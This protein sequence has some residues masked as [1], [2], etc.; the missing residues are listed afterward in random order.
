VE[1]FISQA[2]W[3]KPKDEI[4]SLKS[5]RLQIAK[6]ETT[7]HLQDFK[8]ELVKQRRSMA[9]NAAENDQLKNTV[10]TLEMH[11]MTADSEE[12]LEMSRTQ[13]RILRAD[14]KQR[15]ETAETKHEKWRR[16]SRS[17]AMRAKPRKN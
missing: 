6:D 17:C 12:E 5:E 11:G 9:F 3:T 14:L 4:A 1:T 13:I 7:Q 10:D 8:E 15:R 2:D 16:W